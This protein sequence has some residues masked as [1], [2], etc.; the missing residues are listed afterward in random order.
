LVLGGLVLPVWRAWQAGVLDRSTTGALFAAAW[1][2][3]GLLFLTLNVVGRRDFSGRHVLVLLPAFY[4]LCATCIVELA[5]LRRP[6]AAVGLIVLAPV[7]LSVGAY[8][9][10]PYDDRPDHAGPLRAIA[11]LAAP[12]DV[13]VLDAP[14]LMDVFEYYKP[15]GLP[16]IGLPADYPPD[17]AGTQAAL[18]GLAARYRRVWLVLW[19]EYYADPQG[20][21]P[22]WLEETQLLFLSE[23]YYGGVSLRGYEVRA[24]GDSVFGGVIALEGAEVVDFKAGWEAK[25]RLRWRCLA[26]P[27]KD[28]QVFVHLVDEEGR[29]VGQ[30]DG[31][32]NGGQSPTSAWKMG[33]TV[34]DEHVIRIPAA[35]AGKELQ[36]RVGLYALDDGKRLTSTAGENL[37]LLR[38]KVVTADAPLSPIAG[39]PTNQLAR[40]PG[41]RLPSRTD[42]ILDSWRV[43]VLLHS[44]KVI[45]HGRN[46][47][48][49]RRRR[50]RINPRRATTGPQRASTAR[51]TSCRSPALRHGGS[52]VAVP[53]RWS[54][55]SRAGW[56]STTT[57]I[58]RSC[59]WASFSWR[60]CPALAAS[61]S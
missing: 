44:A 38:A 40:W 29:F 34:R 27:G 35:A 8:Y 2:G 33:D 22:R 15:A 51:R 19:Q 36:L 4:V 14:Y 53:T 23:Q 56:A 58:P 37:L 57:S 60:C 11:A 18:E 28:Y 32:P 54:R 48:R 21:V 55:V 9:A 42:T 17:P 20:L 5:R 46:G 45:V 30:H 10:D 31:S 12:G 16:G 1:L 6:F 3:A 24:P 47:C 61:R 39:L 52:I 43:P 7:L 49:R 25:V 59:A 26:P 41:V 50:W 13:V